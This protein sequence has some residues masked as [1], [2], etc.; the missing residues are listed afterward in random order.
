M[1]IDP[2]LFVIPEEVANRISL[3]VHVQTSKACV[4][5]R[6]LSAGRGRIRRIAIRTEDGR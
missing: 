1:K 6:N 5:R 2:L 4:G 3:N